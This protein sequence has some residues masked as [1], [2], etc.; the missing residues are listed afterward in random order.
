[1]IVLHIQSVSKN[2]WG[3]HPIEVFKLL[4]FFHLILLSSSCSTITTYTPDG[5]AEN[6][7]IEEFE[8]YVEEVFR[9]QNRISTE[10]IML[11]I[12]YD[13]NST[14]DQHLLLVDAEE[15]ITD[16]CQPLN[17]MV[18]MKVENRA[19]DMSLKFKIVNTIS[20]CEYI[21]RDVEILLKELFG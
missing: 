8:L 15:K 6:R 16:A 12:D 21:T 1:M 2:K 18:I 9:R 7:S 14:E 19:I 4:I 3:R 5:T 20:K 17:T 13:L 11:L 10:L